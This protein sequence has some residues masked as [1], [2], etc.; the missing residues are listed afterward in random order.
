METIDCS[1]WEEFE[2]Q[3]LA[4]SKEY[5]D[6]KKKEKQIYISKL[7]FRGQESADWKLETTLER[8]GQPVIKMVDYYSVLE[9]IIPADNSSIEKAW[10][11][12]EYN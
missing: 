1:S 12:P 2:K 7:L 11:L 6:K 8:Y 9:M 4:I 10:G 5:E 3:V